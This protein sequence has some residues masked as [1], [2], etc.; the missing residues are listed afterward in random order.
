VEGETEMTAGETGEGY[1]AAPVGR[2]T[3]EVLIGIG[4]EALVNIISLELDWL[5]EIE[6]GVTLCGHLLSDLVARRP[7]ILRIIIY[8]ALLD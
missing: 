8:P 5:V 4:L 3:R 2:P 7:A 6:S 1:A